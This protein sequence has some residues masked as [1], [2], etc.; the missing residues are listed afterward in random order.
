MQLY[1]VICKVHNKITNSLFFLQP[2]K[3]K[4]VEDDIQITLAEVVINEC[5]CKFA[6]SNILVGQFS[7]RTTPTQVTYRSTILGT[8]GYNASYL[9]DILQGWVESGP[10]ITARQL[11][12]DV[13]SNCPVRISFLSDSECPVSNSQPLGDPT[14]I[15]SDPKV[16]QCV[17]VCLL[18]TQGR[19]ICGV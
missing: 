4:A 14:L 19:G 13:S 18:R 9:L 2:E 15:T 17:H 10:T 7:C 5:K 3:I 16:I 1:S 6:L 12:L 11:L 8:A